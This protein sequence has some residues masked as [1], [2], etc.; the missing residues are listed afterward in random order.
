MMNEHK[1]ELDAIRESTMKININRGI[2]CFFD[3]EDVTIRV[4]GSLWN[5]REVVELNDQVVSSKRSFRLSTPHEFLHDGHLYLVI[6]ITISIM[7]GRLEI[8]LYRDGVLLDS[9]Q[10]Q[11]NLFPINPHTG[12]ID[13]RKQSQQI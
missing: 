5:G 11:P 13:W 3:V 12:K 8:K 4:W 9:D 7:H 1:K 10:A 6:F 2:E